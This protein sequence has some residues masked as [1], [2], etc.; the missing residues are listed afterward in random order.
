MIPFLAVIPGLVLFLLSISPASAASPTDTLERAIAAVEQGRYSE[1]LALL[2]SLPA[3]S[4][5]PQERK[6]ARYLEGHAAFKLKRFP[7]ALYAFGEAVEQYPE[8]ADYALW[9]IAR[10]Y[11]EVNAERFQLETLRLLLGRFPQSRLIPHSRLALARELVGATGEFG[12]GVQLLEAFLSEHAADPRITEVYL[13][14]GQGYEGMGAVDKAI[15]TY[16]TLYIRFPASAEADQGLL[17]L[18]ALL[19]REQRPPMGWTPREQLERA[20]YLALA[21]ACERVI[22]EVRGLSPDT[23]ADDLRSRATA[24][25]GL[26]AFKLRRYR[27]AAAI[28][29]KFRQAFFTDE[30]AGEVFYNL[31]LSYQRDGRTAEAEQILRQLAV[32]TPPTP[33]NAKALTGLGSMYEARQDTERACEVYADLVTRF[34]TDER[35]DEMAW[36]I[37]WLRY[38]QRLYS[39]AGR[40]FAAA[41]ERFPR[42]VFVSNARYWQAK[43]LERSGNNTHAMTLYERVA[44]E[45]PYTY[46]GI[47]AEEIM[48]ARAT[49]GSSLQNGFWEPS[50]R[51]TSEPLTSPQ[52]T[53]HRVRIDELLALRFFE[54][55]REEVGQLAK[56]LGG[57]LPEQ[58]L[59]AD[60][61]LKV[62]LPLQGIRALNASLSAVDPTE[63]LVLPIMFWTLLFPQLYWN[64]VRET[65]QQLQ[66]DPF[67]LLGV[68]RQ[69]SAFNTHAV[70]RSD[71]RGLMQ[72]LP[73]TG[74]ELFQRAGMGPFQLDLLFNPR[75]NVR[76][77][78]QYL[79]RLYGTH[80]GNVILTLAAYNAGPTR[81]KRWL[82]EINRADWD[83]FI[84]SLPFEETR[85]YIKNVLRNY[86]VYRKLY[87]E[88]G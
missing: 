40:D 38:G 64:E 77:G 56:R 55:A 39:D 44:Q 57:E 28:L 70:S 4:L 46:Y 86:G 2:G 88:K 1:G 80:Q 74:R 69:E 35:A 53:F 10:L 20:D 37:G 78:A 84:E 34:P 49:L 47:R 11:R 29:E 19:T 33:W 79:Q 68:I 12:N 25:L 75:V 24:R 5:S 58:M 27:E 18:E 82:Q 26:C 59:L 3:V 71:A 61:Y 65:A 60:L 7:D 52:A 6:R 81:V 48:L 15:D 32:R 66:L 62:G 9:N 8:L 30:R 63:R 85:A 13:L 51:F 72:I 67:L 22:Q 36:R 42:S 73:S 45:Y 54:D 21:G 31:G 16:R 50:P 76:L 17:R 87:P 83:E 14:L 41:A 43:A 23:L